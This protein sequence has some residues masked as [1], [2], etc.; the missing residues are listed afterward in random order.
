MRKVGVQKQIV[1]FFVYCKKR[2]V[3]VLDIARFDGVREIAQELL[4]VGVS[5][6]NKLEIVISEICGSFCLCL[7]GNYSVKYFGYRGRFKVGFN[8]LLGGD[9]LA[10][11]VV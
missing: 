10:V 9:F 4:T 11:R 5:A 6:E 8:D 2:A 3:A 7:V 1:V